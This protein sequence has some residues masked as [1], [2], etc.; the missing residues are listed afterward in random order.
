MSGP[1]EGFNKIRREHVEQAFREIDREGVGAKGGS[2]FVKIGGKE[3]PAKRVLRTAYRLAN[4]ADISTSAFSGGVF[5]A[6]IL[7]GL[8]VEVV[9]RS[10]GV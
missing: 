8:G 7:E 10:N 3:L 4:G 1:R 5:T 9:V 2:Y 6:R